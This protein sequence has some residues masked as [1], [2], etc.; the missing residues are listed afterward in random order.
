MA[1]SAE[2]LL[3][4]YMIATHRY[5][6]VTP[7]QRRRLRKRIRR[8]IREGTMKPAKPAKKPSLLDKLRENR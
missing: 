2:S 4:Q 1:Q 5:A 8:R 6:T 3:R 7:K